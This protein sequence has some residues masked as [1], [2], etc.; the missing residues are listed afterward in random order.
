M[1]ATRQGGKPGG[2]AVRRRR[3]LRL[4]AAVLVTVVFWVVVLLGLHALGRAL[5]RAPGPVYPSPVPGAPPAAPHNGWPGET[6]AP[7]RP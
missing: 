5:D 2:L 3:L 1:T 7:R 6:L 4:L